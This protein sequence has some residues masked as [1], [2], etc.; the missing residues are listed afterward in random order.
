MA[1]LVK[2]GALLSYDAYYML[3]QAMKDAGTVTDTD[4]IVAA[5]EN[6]VLHGVV[7]DDYQFDDRHIVTH[8]TVVCAADPYDGEGAVQFSCQFTPPPDSPP[9]GT[10]GF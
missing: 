3:F 9:P 2:C 5:L 8:G 6:V 7:A 1:R 10:P 4:A